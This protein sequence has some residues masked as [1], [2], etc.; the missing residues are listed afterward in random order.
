MRQSSKTRLMRPDL[1]ISG[2]I[3]ADGAIPGPYS[4]LA[5]GLAVTARFDGKMFTS[6]NPAD[7]TFY[8]ELKPI[9]KEFD[10]EALRASGLDR[11]RL[12]REGADP[13]RAMAEA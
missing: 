7:S 12:K 3:E 4:M 8:R 13:A 11:E 1:Y 2:D 6:L 9:S 10:L 5:F